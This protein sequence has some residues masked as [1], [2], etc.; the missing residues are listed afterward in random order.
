M[1]VGF[2]QEVMLNNFANGSSTRK[3]ARELRMQLLKKHLGTE[4]DQTTTGI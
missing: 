3:F 4:V 1:G 2:N